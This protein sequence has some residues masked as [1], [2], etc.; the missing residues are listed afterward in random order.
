MTKKSAFITMPKGFQ[1][2]GIH[3]GLKKNSD[4]DLAFVYSECPAVTAGVYTR[5]LVKGHSLLRTINIIQ[6]TRTCR[7]I[8]INSG[9]ANACIGPAGDLD[10]ETVAAETAIAFGLKAEE[11]LTCSTGVIGKRMNVAGMIEGIKTFPSVISSSEASAHLAM[12]A[13]MTTDTVPKE[14]SAIIE[15]DGKTV[16]ISGMAKGSGMIHP[17]LAT[18]I[19]VFTTDADIDADVLDKLLRSAIAKTF[20]RVSV[21]GD[22]SVCD[23]VIIMANKMSGVRIIEDTKEYELFASALYQIS[24]D[25]SRVIAADGE[26]ATKLIEVQVSGA[27]S[28]E[29]ALLV[30][31][32][33]CR[34]PLCKTAIF[35]EDANVGRILTAAGYSG[36]AFDPGQVD[37]SLGDLLV[38]K[39]GLVLPFDEIA[40]KEILAQKEILICVGLNAGDFSDRMWTCDFSYDYVK[41]NGS[42]RS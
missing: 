26:G 17:D 1:A 8:L 19:G 38:C 20:N 32:S 25:I 36:A 41:I 12:Q 24:E 15:M 31:R 33:I 2:A 14:S 23:S 42:Y 27:S 9:S 40:A 11:I 5:N 37:I 39:D 29:D 21:D 18:M 28:E 4:P 13:I 10:A 6:S 7:G 16:V 34:S 3:C 22:T 30:V 35:G